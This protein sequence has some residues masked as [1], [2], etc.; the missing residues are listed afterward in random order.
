MHCAPAL[1]SISRPVVSDLLNRI[2]QS[3]GVTEELCGEGGGDVVASCARAAV[4]PLR[5][6]S[7]VSASEQHRV[8][9][10]CIC[11][12]WLSAGAVLPDRNPVGREPALHRG[13]RTLAVRLPVLLAS[14]RF[15]IL[16]ECLWWLVAQRGLNRLHWIGQPVR[17]R[18]Q[19]PGGRL[20]LHASP[21][22]AVHGST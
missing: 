14:T 6:N 10:P 9:S 11:S 21:R 13:A 2:G 8:R 1:V 3:C 17:G 7:A 16:P 20:G 15:G 5:S 18:E 4:Q 19:V 22:R 12:P